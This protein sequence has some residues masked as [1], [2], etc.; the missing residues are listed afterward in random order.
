MGHPW[1]IG[2]QHCDAVIVSGCAPQVLE[3]GWDKAIQ[4]QERFEGRK[5]LVDSLS[6]FSD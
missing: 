4:E 6:T 5:H 3:Q 2:A 1:H